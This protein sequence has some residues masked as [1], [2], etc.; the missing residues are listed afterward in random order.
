MN[1]KELIK[2]YVLENYPAAF[3]DMTEET[4]LIETGVLDS[5]GII[6]L[7]AYLEKTFNVAFPDED[8]TIENFGSINQINNYLSTHG[9]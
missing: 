1:K 4:D 3:E 8:I 5:M 9:V 2:Q 6:E 7:V